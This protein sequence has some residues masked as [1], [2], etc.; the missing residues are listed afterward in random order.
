MQNNAKQR[1]FP[2]TTAISRRFTKTPAN[3][4]KFLHEPGT[5]SVFS[6]EK[7][8]GCRWQLAANASPT[9]VD[10]PP[11]APASLD[12]LAHYYW[13]CLDASKVGKESCTSLHIPE[14]ADTCQHNSGTCQHMPEHPSTFPHDRGTAF[15]N[16]QAIVWTT[17][18]SLDTLLFAPIGRARRVGMRK[19]ALPVPA[20]RR[21]L[22]CRAA[23]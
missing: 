11:V 7:T 8:R 9:V 20:E 3:S 14:H 12:P 5:R 16:A 13:V 19:T 2:K 22:P 6:T 1:T 17:L 4:R 15:A 21:D 23:D 18:A 10:K